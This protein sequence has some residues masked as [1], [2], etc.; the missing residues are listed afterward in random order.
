MLPSRLV[1]GLGEPQCAESKDVARD[2][3]APAA[4]RTGGGEEGQVSL[5]S[6][7]SCSKAASVRLP[8]GPIY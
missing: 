8:I 4:W 2:S 5:L 1:R 7:A 3:N 6:V